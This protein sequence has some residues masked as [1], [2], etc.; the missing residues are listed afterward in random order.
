MAS[1]IPSLMYYVFRCV[2]EF[3]GIC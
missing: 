2:D 3:K 1:H